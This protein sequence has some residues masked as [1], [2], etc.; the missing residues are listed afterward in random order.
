MK[1]ITLDLAEKMVKG[2]ASK[3]AL[4][5]HKHGNDDITDLDASKLT[6]H[7][8]SDLM[9]AHTFP[10]VDGTKNS[11][12][13]PGNGGSGIVGQI[14]LDKGIW[15]LHV[16]GWNSSYNVGYYSMREMMA[17]TIASDAVAHRTYGISMS[18]IATVVNKETIP[19]TYVN[20]GS[21]AVSFSSDDQPYIYA[22]K[23]CNICLKKNRRRR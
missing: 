17:S 6:G 4:K 11:V 1:F 21:T 19:L 22:Y 14:T 5:S 23:L 13:V 16:G 10:R 3:V 12:V 20:W 15:L 2:I 8:S 7:I 9:T 18:C